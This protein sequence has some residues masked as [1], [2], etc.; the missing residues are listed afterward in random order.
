MFTKEKLMSDFAS[1]GIQ[2]TDAVFVHSSVKAVGPVE[3]GA[4]T[5]LDAMIEYLRDGL[6][7]FPAHTWDKI[8]ETRVFDAK[9]DPSCVGLLS[10]L[11]LKRPDGVRSLNPSHSAVAF[12]KEAAEYVRGDSL[13]ETPLPLG[14]TMAQLI[15]RK[16]I[17]LLLGCSPKKNTFIHCVEEL[18][19]IPDRID[20]NPYEVEVIA[21]DGT[22]SRRMHA[23]HLCSRGEISAQYDRAVP[24]LLRSGAMW[25]G[26]FGDALTFAERADRTYEVLS[27]KLREEP[28]FF[29]PEPK[30]AR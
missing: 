18:L 25:T 27:E 1:L 13:A 9:N 16:G 12:G 11:A 7:L 14:S 10:N 30:T 28:D 5:I 21:Q 22:R 19:N 24:L 17:I 29:V 6:L 4:E 20:P 26:M 15:D 8:G 2:P 23:G 3:G